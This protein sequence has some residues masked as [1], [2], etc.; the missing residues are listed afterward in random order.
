[1]I[2]IPFSCYKV[3]KNNWEKQR[4]ASKFCDYFLNAAIRLP[5]PDDSPSE[6]GLSAE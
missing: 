3:T 4:F 1:M 5:A 2:P 6:A